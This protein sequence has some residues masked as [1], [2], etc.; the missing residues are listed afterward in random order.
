LGSYFLLVSY[1]LTFASS[2]FIGLFSSSFIGLFS[3]SSIGSI[4]SGDFECPS[5]SGT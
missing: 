4:F 3:S 5:I 2:S 1:T